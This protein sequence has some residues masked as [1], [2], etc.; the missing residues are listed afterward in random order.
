M[1]WWQIKKRR[2]DLEREL[3]SDLEL[4]EEEQQ[5]RG[6]PPEEARSAARRAF[7][8]TTLIKE[9]THEAW[10]WGPVERFLQDFRYALRQLR[11]FPGFALTIVL[12][13]A[14]GIGANT[15]IFSVIDAVMFR[16][17]PVENPQQL[18]LFTWTSRQQLKLHGHSD[19]GDCDSTSSDCSLSVPFFR[20]VRA[21][22]NSFSSV[23]AFAGPL[24]V[25]FLG[26]GSAVIAH[27]EYVSGDFFSTLGIKTILGRQ[28]G[29]SD[30]SPSAPP[31]IVLDYGYWQ[32]AFGADPSVVGRVVR[33]NSTQVAIVGVVGPRFR[34][35]T[36][37]KTQ[38]FFMPLSLVDRV[39]NEWW[40]DRDRLSD[41]AIFWVSMVGRLKPE[42]SIGQA[43]VEVSNIF[44]NQVLHGA[45]PLSSPADSPAIRLLP[46][47]Q[48]LNGE[49]VEYGPMLNL[50]MVA[51][52]LVLLVACA[53]VA[54]LMLARSARRQKEMATRQALGASRA[55][56]AR[57]LLTESV[58][59][60]LAGGVSGVLV[61]IWGVHALVQLLSQGTTQPFAFVIAP[62]WRVLAFTTAVTL[63]TGVL[64]GLA[65]IF[66]DARVDLTPFLKESAS[67]T[68][69]GPQR[70]RGIRLGDTF[71]IVQ[72]ALSLVVLAGA[73]LLVRTLTNLHQ[74]HPG[75]DT[76]NVLLFGLNPKIAGYTDA[77]TVELYRN[78][79]QR[80]AALPGVV[81]A[82]YSEDALVSQSISGL[83]VHLDGAAPKSNIN[84]YSLAVGPGFFSTMHIPVLSGRVF[85][86]ADFSSAFAT[87]AAVTAAEESARKLPV[88]SASSA[89]LISPTAPV[90]AH[91][92]QLA[93]VP[94]MINQA[95][96]LRF[97]PNRNPL[98][99]HIG[100]AQED[101]PAKGPQPGF[102]IVG[103]VGDTKYRDLRGEV[104]PMMFLP[105]VGN[106]AH[107]ELRSAIDPNELV[108]PVRGI[109]SAIDNKL[110]L[111][112]VRTQ[113]EQ[114]EQTLFRERIT[115]RLS[116]FFALLA[117]LLACI[118]LYGLMSYTVT[119]RTSEIG[120][121][122]ALGAERS[123]IAGMVLRESLLLVLCGLL[124]GVP[125][126]A[127]ASRLIANQLFG[128]KPGDPV[129]LLAAC[130]L[131]VG[132]ATIASYLPA[133]RAASV[134]PMQALRS[135]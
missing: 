58:V 130:V 49:S 57:Q 135:E 126:A 15:A 75:F 113:T 69:G 107:F 25:N 65:P 29:L 128:L 86:S 46:A 106:S 127:F 1:K 53:N 104:R 94:V 102:L 23:A 56:I 99:L 35:L 62:D 3:L 115:S 121:R 67:S 131:M 133:R 100:D 77:Q 30:D 54:G 41:P 51:V 31:V 26:E 71:V 24:E 85:S 66:R 42:V 88:G 97:F 37:G 19:F 34:H 21:Q 109:V 7:G 70:G 18:V 114:I 81:S 125:A 61:S 73:G 4:E 5:E 90:S 60:S 72:V 11:R 45:T 50:I 59:L 38:D 76:Q 14:L 16:A 112:D 134:D 95:F 47:R 43:Q 22:A 12:I 74:L 20:A 2:A 93:P 55:R 98:G 120:I 118:G 68:L 52:G 101:E 79:Q 84:T 96:A 13:L 132:V 89:N 10:G 103:I 119:R 124:V 116:S 40:N 17:L 87:N 28:L 39:R 27:G 63:A 83:D 9:Q 44:R 80:L 122:M 117:L 105:L 91:P 33:V 108:K 6:L 32:R 8:N 82:S 92:L 48:G 129:T 110:P 123:R 111:F 64:S 36:P 78:V